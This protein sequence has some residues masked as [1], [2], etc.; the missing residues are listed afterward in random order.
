MFRHSRTVRAFIPRRPAISCD[1]SPCSDNASTRHDSALVAR[2]GV[3]QWS[4]SRFPL[5]RAAILQSAGGSL[6]APA[7]QLLLLG[8]PF[9]ARGGHV[10]AGASRLLTGSLLYGSDQLA[11]IACG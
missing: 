11:S 8:W 9:S 7:S 5:A 6:L 1:V 4:A 10:R 3:W 2:H